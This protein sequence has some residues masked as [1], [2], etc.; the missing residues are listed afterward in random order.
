MSDPEGSEAVQEFLVGFGE[1]GWNNDPAWERY[2]RRYEDVIK[3]IAIKCTSDVDMQDDCAQEARI[4][5]MMV[6]PERV[7]GYEHFV[8]GE[9]TEEEWNINLD[10]YCRQVVHF[11]ILS[12]LSSPNKGPWYQ[13]RTKR[14]AS[15]EGGTTKVRSSAFFVRLEE[16]LETGM[17]Q[18]DDE[19]DIIFERGFD[20]SRV[21][22]LFN[23]K[24]GEVDAE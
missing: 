19:G 15:K 24:A 1:D 7:R 23:A 4:A 16:L 2:I 6:W 13:S 10:K 21:T 17:V 3:A 14:V 22:P 9:F 18:I 20:R 5:L 12:W 11:S 8:S